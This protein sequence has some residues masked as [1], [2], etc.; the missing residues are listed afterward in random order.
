[1]SVPREVVDPS[2]RFC[3]LPSVVAV[4]GA[5]GLAVVKAKAAGVVAAGVAAAGVV[6]AGVVEVV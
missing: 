2:V 3:R 1:M 5:A 6:V 4:G